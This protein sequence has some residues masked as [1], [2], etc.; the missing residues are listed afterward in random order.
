MKTNNNFHSC[1]FCGSKLVSFK[2]FNGYFSYRIFSF[3]GKCQKCQDWENSHPLKD[4]IDNLYK[5]INHLKSKK[6]PV[7]KKTESEISKTYSRI[8]KLKNKFNAEIEA[9]G[10]KTLGDKSFARIKKNYDKEVSK[11]KEK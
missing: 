9:I 7:N 11:N 4:E 10:A 2:D 1:A 5:R 6:K 8:S 3:F